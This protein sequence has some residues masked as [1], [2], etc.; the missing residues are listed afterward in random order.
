[1]IVKNKET[2][3]YLVGKFRVFLNGGKGVLQPVNIGVYRV[4]IKNIKYGFEG[5]VI[6]Q[7]CMFPFVYPLTGFEVYQT[8]ISFEFLC[9]VSF[10]SLKSR[11]VGAQIG[12]TCSP[13]PLNNGNLPLPFFGGNYPIVLLNDTY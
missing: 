8:W 10:E 1:M 9:D 5:V 13:L 6:G 12:I 3:P 2:I 11:E 4:I 7:S